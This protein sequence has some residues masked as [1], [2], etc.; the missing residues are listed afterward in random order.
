MVSDCGCASLEGTGKS[1]HSFQ[2]AQ[3][4]VA[5]KGG[6]QA[7][8]KLSIDPDSRQQVCIG[9]GSVDDMRCFWR[10]VVERQL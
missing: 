1:L 10:E 8:M 3:G 9:R 6:Q 7:C 2:I 4:Y 5:V